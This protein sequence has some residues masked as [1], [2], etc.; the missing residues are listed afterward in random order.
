[1]WTRSS[2]TPPQVTKAVDGPILEVS[3]VDGD[4]WLVLTPTEVALVGT[5]GLLWRR[6]WHEV[7]RGEWDG[8][9]H[10]LTVHWVGERSPLVLT[11]VAEN[12]RTLPLA[13]RERVDA[14]VVFVE[15]ERARGGGTLRAAV[16]RTPD[17]GL[18]TQVIAVGRVRPGPDL[19]AQVDALERRVRD[20]VGM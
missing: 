17:G 9:R 11:T 8:E 7:E 19:D 20:A 16:R 14:S 6:P 18:L 4:R 1:M 5:D 2:R 3:E 12:P 10:A 13:F 15:T